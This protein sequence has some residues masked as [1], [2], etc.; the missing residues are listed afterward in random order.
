MADLSPDGQLELLVAEFAQSGLGELHL[1][2]GELE[3]R[4]STDAATGR[5]E[6]T[7]ARPAATEAERKPGKPG[8]LAAIGSLSSLPDGA[9]VVR[10]PNLG[11]FYRAPKPGAEVYVEAGSTVCADTEVCLI[12]VMKLFTAVPAGHT[13][14]VYSILADDGAMVEAGQPL[15][16]IVAA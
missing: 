11:T 10:A 9:I 13:G 7:T 8:T 1:R 5:A 12:E 2:S 4:L 3:L 15:F 6:F 14:Q 16:A